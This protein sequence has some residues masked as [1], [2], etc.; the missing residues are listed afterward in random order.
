[1]KPTKYIFFRNKK[2]NVNESYNFHDLHTKI[3]QF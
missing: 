3:I 1:M 2:A